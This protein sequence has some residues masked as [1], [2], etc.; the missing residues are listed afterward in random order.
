[1]HYRTFI[2]VEVSQFS[3]DRLAG[4]QEQLAA[5]AQGVKWVETHNHHMTLIFLGEV[6]E[7]EVADVCRTVENVC[8]GVSPF[9]YTIQ[10]VSAFP[11]PR[12]PRILIAKINEG[13]EELVTLQAALDA[14]LM[15]LGC[16]RREDRPFSPHVTIGRVKKD[17]GGHEL[18]TALHK[19][20]GWSGG[21]T[22]VEQ[23]LT[24]ASELGPDGPAYTVLSRA[25]LGGK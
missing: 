11:T 2:A 12:R 24:M 7:R 25:K 13:A 3:R 9:N 20:A 17:G 4:V 6:D 23:V 22:Q 16:Y 18:A 8:R 21:Q 14:S 10:G 19:F 15:D 5:V 1:M